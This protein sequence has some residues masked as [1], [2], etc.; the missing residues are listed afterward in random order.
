MVAGL[1]GHCW[2]IWRC[3]SS[4]WVITGLAG[5]R[6]F[7]VWGYSSLG[8]T[9]GVGCGCGGGCTIVV[10]IPIVVVSTM[11]VAFVF[12]LV[13]TCHFKDTGWV[14]LFEAGKWVVTYVCCGPFL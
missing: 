11:V 10:V 13:A 7:I 12:L 5:H 8:C 14:S 6:W 4:C 9:V 2:V 1:A 3:G